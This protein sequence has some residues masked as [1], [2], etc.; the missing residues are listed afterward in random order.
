MEVTAGETVAIPALVRQL[1]PFAIT[2]LAA[3]IAVLFGT[4]IDWPEYL[5]SIAVL[6]GAWTY[7]VTMGLRGLML[8]GTALGSLGFLAALGLMRDSVGGSVAAVSIVTLLPVMQTALYVRERIGLWIVLAGV[9]IFYLAPLIFIGPPRYP[10]NGYRGALLAVLVSSIVGL[11]V[12]ELVAN[13]RRRASEARRRESILSR[14]SETV[15]QLYK[16]ADPRREGCRAVAEVSEAL[17]VGLY[18]PDVTSD[19]LRVTTTTRSPEAVVGG[20]PARAGSAVEVAFRTGERQLVLERVEDQVGNVEVWRADGAPT[21]ALYEPLIR[22]DE[23]IGVLFAGWTGRVTAEG[24]RVAVA[25][26]VAREIAA[27]IDRR[28]VIDQLTDEAFTDALTELPNRRAWETQAATAMA[29]G[30]EPVAVAMFDIDRFKQFNDSYGHPAGDRLLRETA[31]AWRAEIRADDFLARLGGEEFALLL[32]GRDATSVRALVER[33]RNSMPAAQT[34]SAGI[35][36]RIAGETPEQLLGRADQA[37]Y[38]AKSAG[39]DRA[40]FAELPGT[41]RAADQAALGER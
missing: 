41:A 21:A 7:G 36:L 26:L 30:R 34:V 18:E 4:T 12:H 19:T 38:E 16:S 8:T 33:L 24:A 35:A 22:G 23:V 27:V 6:A 29:A 40:V 15:Q 17:V 20:A 14:V 11:A 1:G 31:A 13:I 39:R 5:I 10:G 9:T 28:D 32:T 25:S 3:W 2:A 37:L